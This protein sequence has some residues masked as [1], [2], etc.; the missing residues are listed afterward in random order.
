MPAKRYFEFREGSS[1]KFWEVW[2]VGA[3]VFTRYGKIGA[4][5]QVTVKKLASKDAAQKQHD[6]LVKEKTSKGYREKAATKMAEPASD[7]DQPRYVDVP[8]GTVHL[9]AVVKKK[10]MFWQ[11]RLDK[12]TVHVTMGEVGTPGKSKKK[13]HKDEWRALRPA[14]PTERILEEGLRLRAARQAA[15]AAGRRGD[16]RAARS[17]AEE[18][19]QRRSTRRVRGLV[20]RAR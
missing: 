14:G 20:A 2:C 19:S 10:L 18:R 13:T 12:R 17:A 5:G 8:E 7:P 1:N 6:Q 4:S 15:E 9:E 11:S 16:E 3:E